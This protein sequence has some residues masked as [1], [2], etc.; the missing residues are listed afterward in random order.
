MKHSK[1][2]DSSKV[3]YVIARLVTSLVTS[4]KTFPH[5]T[6]SLLGAGLLLCSYSQQFLSLHQVAGTALVPRIKQC[7]KQ[8]KSLPFFDREDKY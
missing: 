8:M 6:E 3:T 2:V 7:M 5:S 4:L 1:D